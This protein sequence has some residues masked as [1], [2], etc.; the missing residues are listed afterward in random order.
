[1]RRCLALHRALMQRIG[2]QDLRSQ[3]PDARLIVLP[4]AGHDLFLE[5]PQ[6]TV[7]AIEALLGPS[8]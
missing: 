8:P 5:Q 2:P 7:E 3:R 4:D 6:R 1:M